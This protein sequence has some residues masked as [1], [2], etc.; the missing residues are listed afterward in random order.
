MESA[1]KKKRAT[2]RKAKVSSGVPYVA[3]PGKCFDMVDGV[4]MVNGGEV[5]VEMLRSLGF[6]SVALNVGDVAVIPADIAS[7]FIDQ[8]I[9]KETS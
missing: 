8:K 9:A 5:R 1:P 7:V 3:K 6:S 2:K 4:K